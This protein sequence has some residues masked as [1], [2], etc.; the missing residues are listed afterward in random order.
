MPAGLAELDLT[1]PP[2]SQQTLQSNNAEETLAEVLAKQVRT[3]FSQQ[4]RGS[5]IYPKV[6]EIFLTGFFIYFVLKTCL[7]YSVKQ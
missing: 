6:G 3:F 2:P 5:K 1:N 4:P 7:A